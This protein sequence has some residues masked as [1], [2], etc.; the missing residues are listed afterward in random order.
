MYENKLKSKKIFFLLFSEVYVTI[1]LIHNFQFSIVIKLVLSIC[2]KYFKQSQ[3]F[4]LILKLI[5]PFL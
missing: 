1:N 5:A 3:L 4:V 2:E